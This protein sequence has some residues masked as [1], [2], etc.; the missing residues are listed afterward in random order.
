MLY[1][2]TNKYIRKT[3]D[4][5]FLYSASNH[6]IYGADGAVVSPLHSCLNFVD[7]SGSQGRGGIDS[8]LSVRRR[9]IP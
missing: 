2:D 6:K 5:S 9:C 7:N 8:G 4:L 1:K 3:I